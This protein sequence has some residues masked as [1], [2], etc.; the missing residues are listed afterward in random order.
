M[1]RLNNMLEHVT[2]LLLYGQQQ[3]IQVLEGRKENIER[4]MDIISSDKKHEQIQI[5]VYEPIEERAFN[6]WNMGLVVFDEIADL[7][8]HLKQQCAEEINFKALSHYQVGFIT[9][10]FKTDY[11]KQYIS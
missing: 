3:F 8:H 2:G 5:V 7:V 1:A 4:I 11:F 10:Q 9:Q 6:A